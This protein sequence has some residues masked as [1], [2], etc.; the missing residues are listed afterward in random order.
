M[1]LLTLI[2][3][4]WTLQG[5][6]FAISY[7]LQRQF[8]FFFS[9]LDVFSFSCLIAL[10]RTSGTILNINDKSGNTCLVPDSI[11]KFLAFHHLVRC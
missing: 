11:V 5:V 9:S 2:I 7:H 4:L 1:C 10:A 8:Y 3:C 6:L